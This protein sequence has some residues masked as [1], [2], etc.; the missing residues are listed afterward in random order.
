MSIIFRKRILIPL[1]LILSIMKEIFLIILRKLYR[2][3]IYVLY[4][5]IV[6]KT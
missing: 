1:L 4:F 2:S 5:S 6:R 3:F